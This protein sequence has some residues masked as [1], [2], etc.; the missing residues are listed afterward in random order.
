M[1][2]QILDSLTKL[3]HQLFY[4]INTRWTSPLL[5]RF[6]PAIT[7]LHKQDWFV[8]LLSILTLSLLWPRYKFR[9]LLVFVGLLLSLATTDFLGNQLFKQRFERARPGDQQEVQAIVRSPYGGYSFISNHAANSFCFAAFVYCFATGAGSV[10][11]VI[12]GLVAYSRVYNGVHFPIDILVGALFG[13]FIAQLWARAL[14]R[15]R[16]LLGG[17][18]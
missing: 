14:K 2:D 17:T 11:F 3:D 7:D 16:W 15:S 9:S 13:I 5:D 1:F 4:L 6:F 8:A 10:F 18:K 12:A